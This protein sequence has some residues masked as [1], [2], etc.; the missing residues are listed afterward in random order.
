MQPSTLICC[1]IL[2]LLLSELVVCLVLAICLI[3][4]ERQTILESVQ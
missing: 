2:S 4:R 1:P 3:A